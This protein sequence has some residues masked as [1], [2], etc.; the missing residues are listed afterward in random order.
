[1][2]QVLTIKMPLMILLVL[3][4][5]AISAE[6]SVRNQAQVSHASGSHVP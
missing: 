4:Y 6:W 1:M 2:H 3:V 5:D